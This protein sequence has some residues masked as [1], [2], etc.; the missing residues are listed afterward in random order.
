[1]KKIILLILILICQD[2][3]ATEY[4]V[5]TSGNDKNNGTSQGKA[6]RTISH[7]ASK[8]V[9][10]DIVWI[11]AGNYGSENVKFNKDGKKNRPISFIGYRKKKGDINSM[12]FKYS[13]GKSLDPSKMPLLDGK[14]RAVGVGFKLYERS[15]ILIKNIQLT[16]YRYGIDAL[17]GAN[18]LIIDNVVVSNAGG[19]SKYSPISGGN[20]IRMDNDSNHHNQVR[21]SIVMNATMVAITVGGN[22]NLIENNKTYADQDDVNGDKRSMDYHVLVSGSNNIIRKHYA[23]HVGDLAHTGHGLALKSLGA[24]KSRVEN[25]LIEN[26]DIVNINGSIEFRHRRVKNNIAR[27]IRITGKTSRY[28]GGFHFRDGTSLNI[29]ENSYVKDL[30]GRNGAISFYDTVEDGGTQW[31]GNDNI[32]RN[33]IFE[34]CELGIRLGSSKT[35]SNAYNNKILNC[36]FYKVNTMLGFWPKSKN[37]NNIIQNCIISN[38]ETQYFKNIKQSGWSESYNNYYETK[39]TKP[40]GSGNISVQ[41]LFMNASKGDFRLKSTSKLIDKG[42]QK[43][44]VKK[45]F[46]GNKRPKGSSHDIGAFEY[47][48][49]TTSSVNADAGEDQT[50]CKGDKVILTA[51][52]GDK[53]SWNTGEKTNSITV[54]PNITTIYKVKVTKGGASGND[55]VRVTVKEVKANAGKNVTINKGEEVTLKA[56]GGDS[57]LWST[58]ETTQSIKVS[59]DKSKTYSVTAASEGCE[60]IDKV[61]VTVESLAS[62]V[63][64]EVSEDMTICKGD[65]VTITASGGTDY[66]WSHGKTA[67]E[68]KVSPDKTTTYK[69]TVTDGI[70]KD[71]AELTVTVK[72]VK[73]NAGKDVTIKK[74]EEVTL[75][76]SGGD[77]Y[78]WSTG[79]TTQSITVSPEKSKF[80]SV[81]ATSG[82]CKDIDKLKVTVEA[83]ASPIIAEVSEDMIICKGDEVILTAS[84][85]TDYSWSNGK[86]SSEIKVSP[87]KTTTYEVTVID[88]LSSDVAEVTV[89]IN[90]VIANAGKDVSIDE[91]EEVTLT[92]TG[93]EAYE[94][95]NGATTA[96]IKVSPT[97]AATYTVT[98]SQN[99]CQSTDKVMVS[100]NSSV[101][102]PVVIPVVA[103]V[104]E[105]MI[106]CKGDEVI[107]TA[108]GGT[109]YRERWKDYLRD[110]GESG[111]NHYIYGHYNRW[112]YF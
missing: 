110:Q 62:P 45:D 49:K 78:L 109:D 50:I 8:A 52:G 80:Y 89:T 61:K 1:M 7:A 105:D 17:S 10:G 79:E 3:F 4:Y 112:D 56:S 64:A 2:A 40:K 44:E 69:V 74:G 66:S 53:Y 88:G 73:A 82:G 43:K 96:S 83:T 18:N 54:N 92:A 27:D 68:I 71:E 25:N 20:C 60:D 41:P 70:T 77:T 63:V 104:S 33:T 100:I 38:S 94:W 55:Q 65:E 99:G 67:S 30:K 111:K 13:K 58:G 23:E 51:T 98:V 59:P 101:V 26:C 34:N 19:T 76:A 9:A 29:V 24:D 6:W 95:N 72:E 85:G 97:T 87:D 107:L 102:I 90:E 37:T 84:G 39:F 14:N 108:S 12:Y 103:E 36:T 93:G 48:G 28:S 81:T 22:N 31:S 75:K 42:K 16:N 46:E 47:Q 15:Y 11:K 106:I 35:P 86:T 32:I 57:Y 21:N 91:G 5:S